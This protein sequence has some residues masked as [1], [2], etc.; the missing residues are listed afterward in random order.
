MTSDTSAGSTQDNLTPRQRVQI[1]RAATA[2]RR[3]WRGKLTA[4]TIERVLAES[5][6][7]IPANV[8]TSGRLPVIVERF[9]EDRLRALA[10]LESPRTERNPAVLFLCTHGALRSQI[11]AGFARDLGGGRI[12][13][14][15]GGTAPASSL[16]H[17]VIAAMA[18]KGIDISRELPKPCADE[19]VRAADVVVVMGCGEACPVYRDKRYLDWELDD[20]ANDSVAGIRPLRDEIERHVRGLLAELGV[21]P[22]PRNHE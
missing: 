19:V 7:R 10:R 8:E 4:E 16:N 1:R 11:A 3:R 17:V 6:D 15:S 9:T 2:L 12:D 18:E 22:R 20:P 21:E 14:F 13:V 5:L